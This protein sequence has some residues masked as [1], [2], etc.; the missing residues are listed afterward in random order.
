M[1]LFP[2]D[3]LGSGMWKMPEYFQQVL[4]TRCLS[5][6]YPPDRLFVP[7]HKYNF[8][9]IFFFSSYRSRVDILTR[10]MLVTESRSGESRDRVP[11]AELLNLC[12]ERLIQEVQ[13]DNADAF[14]VIFKRY[15]RLVHVTAVNIL[16][17]AG[18]A[19]DLTQTVFLE[20]YRRL[21]QFDPARG[22]LKVWLLQ[23]AYSRSMHRR[24]YLFVRQFHKQVE[25]SEM[26]EKGSH[27][28]SSRLQPQETVQLTSEV[29]A[30][31]P[32]PQRRTIEMFFFEGLTLREIAQRRSENFSNIR[33]HYYRGLERLRLYIENGLQQEGAR[34]SVVPL[35][36]A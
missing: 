33:H 34:P 7:R 36:E 8:L 32:E 27:W 14:A 2:P 17:D 20:I 25:L 26:E 6:A 4:I 9:F 21:G 12:D 10:Q 22:T 28:S 16:R 15:H 1:A 24:N 18:E 30:V 23:Y 19:E 5:I 11:Y 31:L 3:R 35:G 29:L 13:A